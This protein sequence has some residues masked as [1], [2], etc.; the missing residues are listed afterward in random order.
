[1]EVIPVQA[2][3]AMRVV[4]LSYRRA[5]VTVAV[6]G[7]CV[8]LKKLVLVADPGVGSS[9][10]GTM[11][12]AVGAAAMTSGDMD[13]MA[14]SDRENEAGSAQSAQATSG[15]SGTLV[16]TSGDSGDD[17]LAVAIPQKP[18]REPPNY[19][20]GGFFGVLSIHTTIAFINDHGRWSERHGRTGPSPLPVYLS[21]CRFHCCGPQ[22]QETCNSFVDITGLN[23]ACMAQGL[24][25]KNTRILLHLLGV[26][27]VNS[28]EELRACM[29]FEY[30]K[31]TLYTLPRKRPYEA[32][33][34][35]QED[36][37][38]DE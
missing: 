28:D 8:P 30:G 1:M 36:A 10:S 26:Y 20:F 4:L 31:L 27:V 37:I 33:H 13:M 14:T 32:T 23:D 9:H 3:E 18:S 19:G 35:G 6:F 25:H 15:D 38:D 2:E 7:M 22:A 21:R 5:G 16:A 34:N 17:S 29:Y 12:T 24:D 11:D